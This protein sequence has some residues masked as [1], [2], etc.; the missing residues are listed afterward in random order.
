MS[1]GR[2]FLARIIGALNEASIPHMVAGSF[3]STHHGV[4]RTTQDIDVIIDP[5]TAA[6]EKFVANLKPE[7]SSSQV[8]DHPD[9]RPVSGAPG[10]TVW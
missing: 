4:P 10:A 6:L 7:Y 3:A 9:P 2:D 1:D 8:R 5:T